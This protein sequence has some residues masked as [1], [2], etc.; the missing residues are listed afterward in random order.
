MS[1]AFYLLAAVTA[2]PAL[3]PTPPPEPP[4]PI[5]SHHVVSTGSADAQALFDRGLTLYYAYNGGQ[6]VEDFAQALKRDQRLAIGYWGEALGYGAD[7]NTALD[8]RHFNLAKSAIA[9]AVALETGGSSEER[10]YIDAM[11]K[12]YAGPWRDHARAESE[13]RDAMAALV[14]SYPNDDDAKTLYAEALL[15]KQSGDKL[16]KPDGLPT[17][18]DTKTIVD[19]LDG[20]LAHNPANI[21]ANHLFIHTFDYSNDQRRALTSADRLAADEFEPAAEHLTHMPAHTYVETGE[22]TKAIANSHRAIEMFHQFL[23]SPGAYTEH[24]QYLAHDIDIGLRAAM[25]LG[26]YHN[27][28]DLARQYDVR[29]G[30]KSAELAAMRRFNRWTEIRTLARGNDAP[31][32]LARSWAAVAAGNPAAAQSEV[33]ALRALKVDPGEALLA[34]I[35]LLQNHPAQAIA[36]ALAGVKSE[37]SQSGE[38]VPNSPA[39]ETLGAIYYRVG[40]FSRA[41]QSF[42]KALILYPGDPRALFGL[43]QTLAKLGET[44]QSI[45][46]QARFTAIWKGGDTTLSMTDL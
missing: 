45:A 10:A 18:N 42:Q 30:S 6:A 2:L 25:M 44:A 40:N 36:Q 31:A 5:V 46:V 15:E 1:L 32:R 9:H 11:A 22:Y 38:Y 16:W 37:G 33:E 41:K 34:N 24:D 29:T 3:R 19:L 14:Q 43:S 20:V 39:L 26:N 8:E 13:Y 28:L 12:R 21:M 17:T 27:A 35:A 7:I 23:S 4:H